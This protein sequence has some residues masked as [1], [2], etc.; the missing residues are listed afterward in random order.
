MF[1]YNIEMDN[2]RKIILRDYFDFTNI[3]TVK[4]EMGIEDTNEVWDTLWET[5]K[6]LTAKPKRKKKSK[7]K[8]ATAKQRKRIKKKRDKKI[9]EKALATIVKNFRNYVARRRARRVEQ[10]AIEGNIRTRTYTPQF[11]IPFI[12]DN[13][14]KLSSLVMTNFF[15]PLQPQHII[16]RFKFF[17]IFEDNTIMYQN[18]KIFEANYTRA[19]RLEFIARLKNAINEELDRG[20]GNTKGYD[21]YVINIRITSTARPDLVGGC[22]GLNCKEG[23]FIKFGGVNTWKT[24][25]PKGNENTHNCLFKCLEVKGNLIRKELGIE[26]NIPIKIDLLP[27]ISDHLKIGIKVYDAQKREI[28][29]YGHKYDKQVELILSHQHYLLVVEKSKKCLE[30]G[31]VWYKQHTCNHKRRKYWAYK[32]GE[33]V[34]MRPTRKLRTEP[35]DY[36]K[37]VVYYDF[38]TFTSINE[39]EVYAAG[40]YDATTGRPENFYGKESLT[41]FIK[42]INTLENKTFI[43]H[44]GARFDCYFVVN[45][46]LKQGIEVKDFIMNNGAIMTFKFGKNN[47]FLDSCC[48][49]S[50]KLGDAGK[51]F[52]I[53]EQYWKSEFDHKKIRSWADVELYKEEVIDYLDLDIYCLKYVWEAFSDTIYNKFNI[54]TID[55]ITTSSMTYTLWQLVNEST[56]NMP[57]EDELNFIQKSTYGAN[58]YPVKKHFKSNEYDDIVAGKVKYKDITDYLMIMDVVSLYPTSMLNKYPVGKA[59]WTEEYEEDLMGIWEISFTPP[60]DILFSQLPRKV[61]GGIIHSL[62]KGRGVYN[63]IDIARAVDAGYTIDK[64]HKG[65]VWDTAENVFA[66]YIEDVFSLKCKAKEEDDDVMYAISKLLLNGLYGKTLQ[67]PI[68]HKSSI[69]SDHLDALDFINKHETITDVNILNENFVLY[70]GELTPENKDDAITKPTQLGSFVLGYSRTI[71]YDIIKAIDPTLKQPCFYYTDTDCLHIHGRDMPKVKHLLGDELGQ[72]N[73]DLKKEGRIIEGIY[74]SPKQYTVSYIGNDNKVVGKY[75]CKGIANKYLNEKMYQKAISSNGFVMVGS[76]LKND[77][78]S[79][80]VEMTDRFKKIHYKQNSNQQEFSQFS[81]HLEDVSRT[82]YKNEWNGRTWLG[83]NSFPLGHQYPTTKLLTDTG[84]PLDV[85]KLIISKM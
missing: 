80:E 24:F 32:N 65:L 19:N 34:V 75:K 14:N 21:A 61:K 59:R 81:V 48:F 77:N 69:I 1:G 45:E 76:D 11:T 41:D 54:H 71:M 20:F 64:V 82:F 26:K 8:I 2:Q 79:T 66:S 73:S 62:E 56:I 78:K 52:K 12:A 7:V 35:I 13:I 39:F 55:F 42:H 70:S 51:S 28:L 33:K 5:Y 83:N 40:Y 36:D 37:N 22:A 9:K 63:S 67:K 84:L 25:N 3:R 38:E 16:I 15:D 46:M 30:C 18:R 10:Q 27:T 47:K 23:K 44:N 6:A 60:K 49:I 43:A 29:N 31:Q 57:S 17:V 58:V 53:P 68:F 72:M 74:L 85:A 4:R 50:S